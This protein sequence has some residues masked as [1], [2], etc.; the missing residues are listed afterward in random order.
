ME[1]HALALFINHIFMK[2]SEKKTPFKKSLITSNQI[3][4]FRIGF[5][6]P[7]TVCPSVT[8]RDVQDHD[9]RSAPPQNKG[10]KTK[11]K[12]TTKPSFTPQKA[13]PK[14]LHN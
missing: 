7:A 3:P 9:H 1:T 12:T 8:P 5:G 14:L 6:Y 11:N 13:A 10:Q 2:P 4:T